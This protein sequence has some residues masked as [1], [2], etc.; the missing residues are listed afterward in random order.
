[1]KKY[2][3]PAVWDL[4]CRENIKG[5][6]QLENAGRAW[7]KKSKP[8]NIEELAALISIIRPGCTKAILDGKNMTQHYVDR[9]HGVE[10][11]TYPHESI[12]EI[13]EP[14]YGVLIYQEQCMR[15]AQK[16]AGFS[17]MEADVL[18]KAIG[19]KKADL[20]AKVKGDFIKGCQEVGIVDSETAEKIFSWIEK[21]A[22]YSFN[23]SH[24]V[25]YAI[26]AYWSADEKVNN[27]R[28]FFISWLEHAKEKSKPH[29]EVYELISNAK[30]L[31][32]SIKTPTIVRFNE[33]FTYE[34]GSIRFGIKNIKDLTGVNGDHAITA[35]N[36]TQKELGKKP[37][38]WSWVEVLLFYSPKVNSTGFK[39]LCSVGFFNG[40]KDK[41]SRNKALYEY[42]VFK[43]LTKAEVTWL[44]NNY[45][46]YKW[47]TLIEAFESLAPTKKEGGGTSKETRKQV[48]LNEIKMLDDP[49]YDLSDDPDWVVDTESKLYGCPVTLSKISTSENVNSNTTCK[50]IVDG[51][52]GNKLMLAG[53]ITRVAT[54]KIKKKGQNEGRE[55]CFI[56]IEDETCSIDNVVAFP[57]CRDENKYSLFEGNNVVLSGK[58]DKDSFIVEKVYDI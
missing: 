46:N 17:E 1:M 38:S 4:L 10:E 21:S 34:T 8:Q 45:H 23:K 19:K 24:A 3:D 20:M 41:I 2:D 31:G 53:N 12:K 47:K 37:N 51:K 13:L 26:N 56:T 9:K 29:V 55:M 52:K 5:V 48:V 14:T 25:C 22:R 44:I 57:D 33:D 54:H 43:A 35:V 11:I 18:R 28:G 27:S 36:E 49:P 39:A 16:I 6:F 40:I 42:G 50:E 58:R 15:I 30:A 7:S 32:Y